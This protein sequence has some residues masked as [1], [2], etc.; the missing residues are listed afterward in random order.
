MREY[1]QHRLR[2][3]GRTRRVFNADAL[4]L[5]HEQSGGVPRLVNR[6]CDLS[7]VYAF[8]AGRKQVDRKI[9]EDVMKDGAFLPVATDNSKD[10]A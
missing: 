1:V 8:T 9:V 6:L 5:I 2:V 10:D 4:D 7:L 3:A